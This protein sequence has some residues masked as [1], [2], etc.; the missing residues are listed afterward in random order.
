MKL[1]PEWRRVVTQSYSFW[2]PLIGLLV[3]AGAET[4]AGLTDDQINPYF[5]GHASFAL[6]LLGILCRLVVQPIEAW[7]NWLRIVLL[8]ALSLLYGAT[9]SRADVVLAMGD[10]E[11]TAPALPETSKLP[12]SDPVF[13]QTAVPFIGKWEGLRTTAYL[14]RI[15]RPPVWTVCYGE[16][17]GVQPGDTYTEAECADMLAPRVLEFRH[18]F[19][20]RTVQV[21]LEV[22]PVGRDVAFTS[23]GYNIGQGALAKST[24]LRRLN[25]GDVAGACEALT[26]WNKAGGKVVRGLVRRRADERALCLRSP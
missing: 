10:P 23:L 22:L 14:D 20:D 7:R 3:F 26:W 4:I 12:V 25:A 15:A 11:Q 13:V 9:M 6:A 21:V 8:V 18:A 2:L 24:A 1:I 19:H 16:T 17:R 5:I